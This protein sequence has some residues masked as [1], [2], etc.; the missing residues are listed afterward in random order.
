MNSYIS[1]FKAWIVAASLLIGIE[2]TVYA[3][4]RP[5]EFDRTNF[6]QFAFARDETPQRLF[7][8]EK[9]KAFAES[10]PTIVQS[11]DSSG[12]YGID[13]RQVMSHLPA[14]VSYLNMSCCANLGFRGYYNVLK[15]MADRNQ[16][17]RYMV[18]HITPHT[19]PR[20]ETWDSDGAALWGPPDVKVFGEAVYEEFLSIWRFFHV[21]SL[22]YRR[23]VTDFTYYL[24]GLFNKLDRPL[25]KN[26]NYL[27]F[28]KIFRQ[29]NGWIPENDVRNPIS[30]RECDIGTP[31]FFDF[32]K[33]SKKTYLEEILESYTS[34]ARSHNATLVVV[35]QPVA[36]TLGTGAKNAKARAIIDQFKSAN[37]D[38]EI[39]FPLIETWPAD[40]FSVP[41]HVRH[42]YIDMIGDRLG[43]A[44]AAIVARHGY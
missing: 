3:I 10:N 31:D 12:F 40:M 2:A 33:M 16:S 42:E 17:I 37:P 9:I 11:G 22:A 8:L 30:A 21:P 25:L 43:K 14:G 4:G 15:F 44:M 39:P 28:L 1:R 19:M 35:F 23:Q 38:V 29:T 18:L 13:P 36:C 20:P 24:F 27:D 6:L 26:S 7:V 34:L 41:A 5:S 32:H